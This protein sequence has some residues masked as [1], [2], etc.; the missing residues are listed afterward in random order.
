M[1][2]AKFRWL[3]VKFDFEDNMELESLTEKS[4][5]NS[6]PTITEKDIMVS[7]REE[8]SSSFGVFGAGNIGGIQCML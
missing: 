3:L 4:K 5:H 7:L 8:I 1:V 6:N 2:R